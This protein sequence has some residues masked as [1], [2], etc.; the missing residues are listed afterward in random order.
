MGTTA[1]SH[2]RLLPEV[3]A[4]TREKP[5]QLIAQLRAV[6]PQVRAAL[7]AGHTLQ[8]IHKRLYASGIPIS[9][10]CLSVY[11]GRIERG[12]KGRA[13]SVSPNAPAP[14]KR[15]D[16]APSQ[17]FDP[18]A[19]LRAHEQRKPEWQYPTGP[20]DESKLI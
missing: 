17:A 9:Y 13:G 5:T 1:P 8:L 7:D 14:A 6:W 2:K 12:K 18:I 20:P 10:K 3:D 15:L 4:L 11:R 16:T 19:N